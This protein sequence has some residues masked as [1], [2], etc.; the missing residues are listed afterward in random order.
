MTTAIVLIPSAPL[1]Q[2]LDPR[3]YARVPIDSTFLI[4]GLAAS[5]GDVLTDPTLPVTDV[6]A[7][8]RIPSVGVARTFSLFGKTAQAFAA[9]PYGWSHVTGRVGASTGSVDRDGFADTRLR[10]S[11]LMRG[12]P[13]GSM[14]EI[15]KAPRRVILGASLNVSAPSGQYYPDKLI[16]VGT[17]RW[18]VKPEFAIS[19]PLSEKWLLDAYAGVWL[20]SSTDTFYP[21]T[22]VR[23]QAPMGS[24]QGHLSYTF[25]PQLW[26]AFDTTYYVGGRT[27]I[28]GTLNDDRQANVRL[29][30]TV[31][32]PVG[33]RHSI[34]LAV[35][36]G[37]IVRIGSDFTTYSVAWQTGWIPRPKE[38]R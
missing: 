24:F 18:A 5:H 2:E 9:L 6:N 10:L 15:A 21:G 7:T 27:T 29:G 14:L 11:V 35:A 38:S 17:N 1:A 13:A 26:A 4:V 19:D 30:T 8:V 3:A 25:R 37:A 33:R 31:V 22:A 12:A 34:K 28:Q 32:L 36:K 16:N 20:F 23:S